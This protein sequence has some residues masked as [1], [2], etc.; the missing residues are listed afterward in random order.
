[1]GRVAVSLRQARMVGIL[2]VVASC[3]T[4]LAVGTVVW[5]VMH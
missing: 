3:T 4:F 2:N 5:A 1:L